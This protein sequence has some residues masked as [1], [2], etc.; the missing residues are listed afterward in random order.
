MTKNLLLLFCCLLAVPS[1]ADDGPGMDAEQLDKAFDPFFSTKASGTGLGLAITRQILEDH[2]GVVR[3]GST[4][5]GGTTLELAMPRRDAPP[6][7]G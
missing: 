2:D 5:G 4:P 7:D 1:L 3:V 6:E